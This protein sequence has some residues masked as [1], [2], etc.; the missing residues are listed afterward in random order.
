MNKE[1]EKVFD[2][3]DKYYELKT[4]YISKYEN[5]KKD[6][7]YKKADKKEKQ[8]L[9]NDHEKNKKCVMCGGIGGTIFIEDK[10]FLEALC[11]SKKKC[12]F[13]IKIRLGRRKNFHNFK[14][15]ITLEI[16]ELK[17]KIM[18]LKLDLLFELEKESII[19]AE[20]SVLKEKLT[21]KQIVLSQKQ[22][23]F[24]KQFIVEEETEE[25]IISSGEKLIKESRKKI[26]KELN[27]RI[28]SEVNY[29]NQIL[30]KYK[31]ETQYLLD[32]ES[33]EQNKN[34]LK[35]AINVYI[36]TIVPLME[37]KHE[38]SYQI[39]NINIKSTRNTF[40]WEVYSKF[41]S[42]VNKEIKLGKHDYKILINK[43][44]EFSRKK[45]KLKN[46]YKILGVS[47]DATMKD[48]KKA[49]KN[50]ALKYHPDKQINKT[51]EEEEEAEEKFKE[52][53]NSAEILTSP[54]KKEAYDRMM[55]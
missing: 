17:F 22:K 6:K 55:G 10:D 2:L 48:I 34:L 32:S 26:I 44:V 29:Y 54:G 9:M 30:K 31:T 12:D 35:D 36:D 5:K 27:I 45:K 7:K 42:H 25:I 15:E 37:K 43:G 51:K 38:L 13:H 41:I 4:L 20:F 47:K 23:E 19:L 18:K 33:Q 8:K 50:A 21:E 24:D 40:Q 16:E 1:F 28:K 39:Y 46:H 14:K 49:Y 3:M 11:N 52:I 53:A